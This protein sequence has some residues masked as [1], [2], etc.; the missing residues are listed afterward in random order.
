MTNPF[1]EP[2]T[3]YLSGQSLGRL[4]TIGPD[5]EP[6]VRPVGFRLNDDGTI[7]IGGPANAAS[8]KY[9]NIQADP[10]VSFLVDDMTAPDD[11][12]A[13]RPGWGRGV[14]VRG[15]AEFVKGRMHIGEGYFSDDLIRIRP[16][17]VISWH[18]DPAGPDQHARTVAPPDTGAL[19]SV[20]AG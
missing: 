15:R 7:D 8:R 13:V 4:S 12:D 14:E 6:H 11:P 10:R 16:V 3:A 1:T 5:G 18:L 19:G 2:E 20:S 17:R 9:R